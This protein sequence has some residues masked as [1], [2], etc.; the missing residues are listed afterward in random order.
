M[1]KQKA[2]GFLQVFYVFAVALF[3]LNGVG[4][5]NCEEDVTSDRTF[6]FVTQGLQLHV[7]SGGNHGGH[8]VVV[9]NAPNKWVT[10]WSYTCSFENANATVFVQYMAEGSGLYYVTVQT[11]NFSAGLPLCLQPSASALGRAK[12]FL[13][14][15]QNWL[16]DSNLTEIISTL[17]AVETDQNCSVLFGDLNLTIT[18]N[19]YASVFYWGYTSNGTYSR[20]IGITFVDNFVF[21]RDDRNLLLPPREPPANIFN[22]EPPYISIQANKD[23]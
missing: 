13:T 15:Y 20:G 9:S 1:K 12:D 14:R 4:I 2:S 19:P 6:L 5:A 17:D 18:S 22:S 16:Q 10:D 3:V 8:A 11:T 21:F 23:L 7:E